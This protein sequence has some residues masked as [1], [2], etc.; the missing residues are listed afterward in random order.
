MYDN[1]GA[2]VLFRWRDSNGVGKCFFDKRSL[3]FGPEAVKQSEVS[4]GRFVRA[5]LKKANV[6][7]KDSGTSK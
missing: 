5:I 3:T 6:D 4:V 2:L 7:F 1:N